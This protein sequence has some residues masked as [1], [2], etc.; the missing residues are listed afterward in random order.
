VD[1]PSK[2]KKLCRLIKQWKIFR[3]GPPTWVVDFQF[4][5][6]PKND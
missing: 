4:A 1:K 3:A 2:Y 6:V 5:N